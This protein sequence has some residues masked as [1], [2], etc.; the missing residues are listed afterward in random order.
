[1]R[2]PVSVPLQRLTIDQGIDPDEG[3]GHTDQ[4]MVSTG[5]EHLA[6]AHFI[7][8]GTYGKGQLPK[9]SPDTC[10]IKNSVRLRGIVVRD[11]VSIDH[12]IFQDSRAEAG[13]VE[14]IG[15]PQSW[16]EKRKAGRFGL[17]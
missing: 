4:E 11:A 3:D 9:L 12:D 14:G 13:I 8:K 7:R 16:V 15:Q 2:D 1:M 10:I 5:L 17:Q 6:G